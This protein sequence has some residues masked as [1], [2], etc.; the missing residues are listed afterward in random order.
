M[1]SANLPTEAKPDKKQVP[2][3]LSDEETRVVGLAAVELGKTRSG[4][5]G[6]TAVERA[7]EVL[8]EKNPSALDGTP[9]DLK[10]VA[11]HAR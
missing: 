9:W 7:V 3:Y 6:E 4:F 10:K 2:T 1:T 5:L 8:K 11:T